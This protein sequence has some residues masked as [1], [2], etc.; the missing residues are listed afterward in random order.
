LV[1]FLDWRA[2]IEVK[3]RV[4]EAIFG[5]VVGLFIKRARCIEVWA[6]FEWH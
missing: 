6:G 4:C 3:F 5:V 2:F 1:A